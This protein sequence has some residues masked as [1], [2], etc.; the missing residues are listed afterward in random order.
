MNELNT[1]V[2][3][4]QEELSADEAKASL[5]VSTSLMEQMLAM[6]SQEQ[7]Q[8]MEQE[9]QEMGQEEQEAP[10]EEPEE[11]GE[12]MEGPDDPIEEETE[13]LTKG[14]EEFKGEVKGIIETKIDD[15]TKTI[16]DALK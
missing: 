14:F 11:T 9:G 13:T 4:S 2:V 7:G 8:E 16:K 1:S 6:Q 12:D 5:G 10:Q 3:N 15:L